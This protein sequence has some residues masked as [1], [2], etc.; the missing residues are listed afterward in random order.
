MALWPAKKDQDEDPVKIEVPDVGGAAD[1]DAGGGGDAPDQLEHLCARLGQL[2]DLLGQ[3]NQ[4]VLAYLVGRQSKTSGL[5]AND[6]A[7]AALVDKIDGLTE[8][9]GQLEAKLTSCGARV[10][11]PV[12]GE[13][14]R[15]GD[16]PQRAQDSSAPALAEVSDGVNRQFAALAD[17]IRHL[18]ERL[19]AGLD[20]LAA[21]PG[22][23]EPQEFQGPEPAPV[24]GPVIGPPAFPSEGDVRSPS[25]WADWQ[26]ALLG[27]E[28]AEHPGLDFER[29][30]LLAGVLQGDGGACSLLGQLL[31]FR[32]ARTDKMPP[33]L[34]DIGEAYYRWQP[35]SRPG[36]NTMEQALV[37]WL[38][39]TMQD[40][41]I[42]NTIEVVQPGERF[43]STRHTAST[44]GV[45]ITEVHGWI[46]LRD[47]GKVYTKAS[48]AVR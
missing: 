21:G 9:L 41:G 14:A 36:P 15:S 26:R 17:G 33:L 47:N 11:Q 28:L 6:R 5:T 29:Q 44:R 12:P 25:E 35:K 27:A 19:D 1:H 24:S 18:E 22:P 4:Q 39:E 16:R 23:Q 42:G 38:K 30:R 8:R 32:S 46:V 7:A 37:L 40:A 20:R 34:K 10:S 45:E 43:D 31:V 48:V 3:A 13:V 2:G